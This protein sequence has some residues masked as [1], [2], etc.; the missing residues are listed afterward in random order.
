MVRRVATSADTPVRM[1]S[2]FPKP[3]PVPLGSSCS[4][5]VTR[6]IVLMIV[7]ILPVVADAVRGWQS[8]LRHGGTALASSKFQVELLVDYRAVR[9]GCSMEETVVLCSLHVAAF[10]MF[11]RCGES[12]VQALSNVTRPA[13]SPHPTLSPFRLSTIQCL[14]RTDMNAVRQVDNMI[15]QASYAV[16]LS[17]KQV[18]S[19][20]SLRPSASS[21]SHSPSKRK[22][23]SLRE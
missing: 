13:T 11:Q 22:W 14:H 18:T 4:P 21:R 9:R 19:L 16:Y 17:T 15:M 2:S 20:A 10:S 8:S 1:S 23:K 5:L 3:E 6:R 7:A 12:R